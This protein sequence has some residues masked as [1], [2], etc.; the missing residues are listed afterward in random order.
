[1]TGEGTVE[2]GSAGSILDA[3]RGV[4]LAG[5]AWAAEPLATRAAVLA[6]AARDLASAE[7][8]VQELEHAT[9]CPA[10]EVWS[11]ELLPTV[12]A[13]Q[14]LAKTGRAALRPRRLPGSGLQWFF[15]SVRHTLHWDPL[16]VVGVIS[17]ANSLLFLAVPQIAGAL[18]SGNAVLWKPA[19]IGTGIARAV[20]ALLERAGLPQGVLRIVPGEAEAAQAVVAAG[21]D[22]LFFTGSAR[23][24]LALYRL[25]AEAGRP[26]VLEL[27]G[28]HA[29]VVMADTALA[30]TARGLVWGKLANGGRNCVSVQLVLVERPLAA[31]LVVALGDALAA[32][33]PGGS[34]RLPG[35]ELA[36][37]GAFVADAT[38]RGARVAHAGPAGGLPAAVVDVARGMRVVDEE[39]LGPIIAVAAVDVAEDAVDWINGD[40]ARLSASVWSADVTRAQRLAAR[41]DV[42]QVWINDALH[43]TAQ[44]AVPL[45]GRGRSG[46]G[47]SR[48]LAGLMETV[49]P[50]VVSV[51]PRWAPRF[52]YQSPGPATERLFA[53]TAR[54]AAARGLR[55]RLLA[56]A[57]LLRALVTARG[58]RS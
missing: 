13:L 29:A 39:I 46:F 45:A 31:A 34:R 9:G 19:L 40:E 27:S 25:Q 2:T 8:L 36:R 24:G 10:H 16:G 23:A 4:R 26:A 5:A 18:L 52:H 11:A 15:R 41:L 37:L 22:K 30:P 56:G 7:W 20:L 21:I 57:T 1:M 55:A 14:W 33:W 42:G 48:G 6:R 32:A 12:D 47:A 28:R 51:M 53:A 50:K 49:Q 35:S 54:L 58:R 44:P 43:P 17:P 38:V 3:R